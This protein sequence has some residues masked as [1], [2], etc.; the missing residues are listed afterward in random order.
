[1]ETRRR[2]RYAAVS[3]VVFA[4]VALAHAVR[5]VTGTPVELDD[6]SVPT[7]VS[8]G[9]AVLAGGLAVWGWHSR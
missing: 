3:A 7:T 1:M 6:A 4:L 8:A 5:V 9:V 2:S